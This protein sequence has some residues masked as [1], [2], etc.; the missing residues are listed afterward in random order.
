MKR[1]FRASPEVYESVRAAIDAEWG[2]PA[3]GQE[4]AFAPLATAPQSGGMAYLAVYQSFC[5][6][7]AVAAM[8]PGLLASGAV[9]EID[10]ATYQASLPPAAL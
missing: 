7:D 3:N 2:L 5:E 1:F 10:A 6:Y 8:L 4:T 9:E